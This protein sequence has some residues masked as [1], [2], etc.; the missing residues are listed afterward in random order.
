[1]GISLKSKEN[2]FRAQVSIPPT[3]RYGMN[4]LDH[5]EETLAQWREENRRAYVALRREIMEALRDC[6]LEKKTRKF[7]VLLKAA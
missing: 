6:G 5:L 3:D 4:A 1:M 7:P 2:R